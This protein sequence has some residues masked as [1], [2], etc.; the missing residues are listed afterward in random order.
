[1]RLI[2]TSEQAAQVEPHM[3]HGWTLLAKIEREMLDGTNTATAGQLRIE[4]GAVPTA[5]LPALRAAVLQAT[6]PKATAPKRK[7]QA[8]A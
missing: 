4:I 6:A 1:M 5:S 7:R 3:R 2:L 8:K